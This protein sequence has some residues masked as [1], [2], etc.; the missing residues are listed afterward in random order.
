MRVRFDDFVLD[1][2]TRELRRG[3]TEAHLSPKAF[4]LLV[5]LVANRPKALSKA[6]L[7]ERL[8]PDTFAVEKNLT[9]LIGEIRDALGDDA[10]EP[11]FVRTIYGYGYAFRAPVEGEAGQRAPGTRS[12]V[13][14]LAWQG[15]RVTLDEGE[16]VLGRD[17]DAGVYLDSPGVSRRH[18]LI[19]VADGHA[20]LED[21][22]SKNG[23]RHRNRQVDVATPLAD[24]DTIQVGSVTLTFWFVRAGGSTETVG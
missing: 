13:A 16:H 8:W 19:K 21:L 12:G 3:G 11:I 2:D 6:H 22:G 7:Q 10:S 14:R 24:G 20:T 23:T 9:N 4:E 17:P 18:A 15:G 1:T 5:L